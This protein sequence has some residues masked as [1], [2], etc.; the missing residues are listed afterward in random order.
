MDAGLSLILG[1]IIFDLA[2]YLQHILV[3]KV[4][5]LWCF[6]RV[7]HTD[8]DLDLTSA[9]RFHPVEI[10]FSLMYKILI[11]LIFGLSVETVLIF[12]ILLNF[13]AM[14]NHANI[15]IHPRCERVLRYFVVTPQMHIIH[16]SVERGESDRNYG[17]NLS[18]WDRLFKTYQKAFDS[19]QLIGQETNRAIADQ[20][21]I[22]LLIQ[23][24][25]F[26]RD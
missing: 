10:L 3:H 24:F 23:P 9:L 4:D 7:H 25:K 8:V 2:I 5:F 22:K 16:H 18:I 1:L 12:E 11:I 26:K 6:H 14:F 19:N 13:M 17:F 20:A 21:L 15:A